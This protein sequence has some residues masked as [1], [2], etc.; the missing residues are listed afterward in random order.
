MHLPAMRG[1]MFFKDLFVVMDF[2]ST[3]F[4]LIWGIVMHTLRVCNLFYFLLMQV[5]LARFV[6]LYWLGIGK[7]YDNVTFSAT[8]PWNSKMRY[9]RKSLIIFS[10]FRFYETIIIVTSFLVEP[11]FIAVNSICRIVAF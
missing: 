1:V 3:S 2:R 5:T 6:D 9:T 10:H 4:S 11:R 7:S 8:R